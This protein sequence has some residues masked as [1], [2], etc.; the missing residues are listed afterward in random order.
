MLAPTTTGGVVIE[1]GQ[2]RTFRGSF[3]FVVGKFSPREKP[4]GIIS[5]QLQTVH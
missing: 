2:D 4:S 5:P 3:E 1:V